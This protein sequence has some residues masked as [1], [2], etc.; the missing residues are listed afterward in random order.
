MQR[1]LIEAV[2]VG[3]LC[4][5]VGVHVLLRRLPFVTLALSHATLPGVV[6]ASILGVSL[7][8]GGL[9]AAVV[10]IGAIIIIGSERRLATSTATGVALSGVFALGVLLQ[11][12][13]PGPSKDLA[14][15]LVGDLFT[16][17]PGDITV[18]IV[19]GLAVVVVLGAFH[20]ELVFGAFDPGGAAAAG[21]RTAAIDVLVLGVLAV[22]VV[23]SIP[24]VGTILVVA[25]VVTPALTAR[26]WVDRV[27]PMM[28]LAAALGAAAGVVGI[29]VSA[30]WG[31][32]GGA[33]TALS[34]TA[35]LVL[36]A[37]RILRSRWP[38]SPRTAP[39]TAGTPRAA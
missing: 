25:L 5:A 23:T 2:L 19:V 6:V 35:F 18:T 24:A 33:A 36:S 4:G 31:V 30:Q 8:L 3:A 26:L 38:R 17:Q 14:A 20:K 22:T 13:Q 28:I 32:A 9:A 10:L 37:A 27:G 21:Y 34:A 1:A 12:A 16:V 7:Y 15:F 29:A 39:R 11:S